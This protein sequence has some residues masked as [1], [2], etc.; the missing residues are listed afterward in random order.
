MREKRGISAIVATVMIVLITAV[1]VAVVWLGIIPLIQNNLSDLN[2]NVELTLISEEGYTLW[3]STNRLATVQVERSEDESDI[4]GFD[5]VFTL[6]GNS[7]THYVQ[8]IPGIN[9]ILR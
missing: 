9:S 8:N 2:T 1:A 4:I 5:I 3:D 7:V 6:E